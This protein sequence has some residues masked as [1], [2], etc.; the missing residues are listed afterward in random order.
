M[1][2][3][4]FKTLNELM[5]D[6]DLAPSPA[7][8]Y[9][10]AFDHDMLEYSIHSLAATAAWNNI[11]NYISDFDLTR[12]LK[13][14]ALHSFLTQFNLDQSD[15]GI[16]KELFRLRDK[17]MDNIFVC[18]D[19]DTIKCFLRL[20]TCSGVPCYVTDYALDDPQTQS[21]V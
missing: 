19:W 1:D 2:K 21:C 14:H 5:A 15:E 4:N 16:Q 6:F 8:T 20:M 10:Y 12:P 11:R 9:G 18:K 13:E 7:N 17:I 3:C